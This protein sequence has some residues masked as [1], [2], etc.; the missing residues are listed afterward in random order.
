M[1]G[2][3]DGSVVKG[4]SSS[5]SL[6]PLFS[7]APT[8]QSAHTPQHVIENKKH[9]HEKKIKSELNGKPFTTIAK[10]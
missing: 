6:M 9:K 5:R 8:L 2:L 10:L 3:R 1:G 7:L 4:A